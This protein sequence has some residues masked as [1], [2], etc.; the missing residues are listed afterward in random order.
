MYHTFR[1]K[2][3]LQGHKV[4]VLIDSGE[5]HNFID[6]SLVDRREILMEEFEGFTMIILGG[7]EMECTIWIPKLKITMGNYTLTDDFFVEDV[8]D[9]NVV[10]EVQWLYSIGKYT[11]DQGTMEMEF[12]GPDDKKV[13]LRAMHQYLL[14]IVSSH[15]MEAVMRHGDIE[16]VVE[17]YVFCSEP[18]NHPRQHPN[19][20]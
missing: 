14:K 18:P 11:T 6:A 15:N 2:G 20:I 7:Y 1:V 13:V 9:T 3:V 17:C 16:W 19:D 10:L 5:S 12:M 4:M 8:P